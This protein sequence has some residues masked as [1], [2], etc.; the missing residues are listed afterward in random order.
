MTAPTVKPTEIAADCN[1]DSTLPQA[2]V[3]NSSFENGSQLGS[4]PQGFF[5][6]VYP[7]K[8]NLKLRRLSVIETLFLTSTHISL[9]ISDLFNLQVFL[10]S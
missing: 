6:P 4:L 9:F 7:C 10:N 3:S 5:A 8:V 2:R 1:A